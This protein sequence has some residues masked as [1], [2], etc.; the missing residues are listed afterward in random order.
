[1]PLPLLLYSTNTWLAWA[2]G[3]RYYRELHYCWCAPYFDGRLAPRHFQ[4]PPSSSPA[5]IYSSLAGA[6]ARGDRHSGIIERN[7]VGALRGA[8][9]KRKQGV[10]T[11]RQQSEIGAI[12]ADAVP[13]DFRP[14]LFVYPLEAYELW[15]MRYRPQSEPTRFRWSTSCQA[16]QV[17]DLMSSNLGGPHDQVFQE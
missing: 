3:Q 4:L 16:S 2:I 12:V 8:L 15:P 1:M 5:E 11:R 14:V 7:K 17:G 10:I 6:V 9:A 13:N